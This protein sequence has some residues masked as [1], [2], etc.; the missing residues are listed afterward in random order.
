MLQ[1]TGSAEVLRLLPEPDSSFIP[2]L[3]NILDNRNLFG[4]TILAAAT[5]VIATWVHNEPSS[6]TIIQES[7][8]PDSFYDLVEQGV[9]PMIEVVHGVLNAMG[10]LSLNQAGQALLQSR[11]NVIPTIFGIFTSELHMSP[12]QEK[13]NASLIGGD[14]DELVRHHPWLKASIFKGITDVLGKI[15]AVAR[16]TKP[17]EGTEGHFNL[18]PVPYPRQTAPVATSSTPMVE[19]QMAV[20]DGVVVEKEEKAATSVVAFDLQEMPTYQYI[21]NFSKVRLYCEWLIGYYR[22][23]DPRLF[24]HQFLV[25]F[26]NHAQHCREILTETKFLEQFDTILTLPCWPVE[27]PLARNLESIL[28]VN[29]RL[30][31]ASPAFVLKRRVQCVKELMDSNLEFRQS[32]GSNNKLV[33]YVGVT[34]IC[35]DTCLAHKLIPHS[36]GPGS[37]LCSLLVHEDPPTAFNPS[38]RRLLSIFIPFDPPAIS[39]RA[40]QHA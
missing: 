21:N 23:A 22:C 16:E 13:S 29:R 34:G 32:E 30:A 18:I 27:F 38:K 9:E 15:E 20:D 39:K 36:D 35:S 5:L 2:S 4:S 14:A 33:Q 25:G 12:L 6:L 1:S 11:P 19:S 40:G 24:V 28:L 37:R 31:D 3:K 10:A 26:F 17:K 8:L 7:K